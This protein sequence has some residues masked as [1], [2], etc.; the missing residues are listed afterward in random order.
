MP[1]LNRKSFFLKLGIVSLLVTLGLYIWTSKHFAGSFAA[2]C[3][4]MMLNFYSLLGLL[5]GIF[6]G[7]NVK[8]GGYLVLLMG[9]FAGLALLVFLMVKFAHV[10]LLGFGLGFFL[11]AI[12]ATYATSSLQ[13]QA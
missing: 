11:V 7:E 6:S 10:D 12:S 13:K 8:A 2:G 3:A 4:L 9:K 5:E 1:K